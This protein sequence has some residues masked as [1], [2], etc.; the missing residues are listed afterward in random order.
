MWFGVA[1]LVQVLP[2]LW[3]LAAAD[4]TLRWRITLAFILLVAGKV[5]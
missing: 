4:K 3:Q 2:Y 1:M 5:C